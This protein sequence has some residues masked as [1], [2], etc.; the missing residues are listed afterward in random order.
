MVDLQ[1]T[2]DPEGGGVGFGLVQHHRLSKIGLA[3]APPPPRELDCRWQRLFRFLPSAPSSKG[4]GVSFL[5]QRIGDF[6]LSEKRDYL[7]GFKS[8]RKRLEATSL[9]DAKEQA[10]SFYKPSKVEV[11]LVW[12]VLADVEQSPASL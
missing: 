7:S 12:V 2:F 3:L 4:D 10:L 5:K 8:R 9:A 11:G 1:L 6:R